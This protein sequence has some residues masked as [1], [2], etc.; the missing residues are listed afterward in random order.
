MLLKDK[1]METGSAPTTEEFVLLDYSNE[2]R[3]ER[4]MEMDEFPYDAVFGVQQIMPH[5]S[6][7]TFPCSFLKKIF[8][9]DSPGVVSHASRPFDFTTAAELMTQESD[10]I[11][12]FFNFEHSESLDVIDLYNGVHAAASSRNRHLLTILNRTDTADSIKDF[13]KTFATLMV[14]INR[15]PKVTQKKEKSVAP[16]I[17]TGWLF[18]HWPQYYEM[19][20][21]ERP[22]YLGDTDEFIQDGHK[23]VSHLH[24]APIYSVRAKL[25]DLK[26]YAGRLLWHLRAR[27]ELIRNHFWNAVRFYGLNALLVCVFG[28]VCWF[29][30][31]L[32]Y[33]LIALVV[34]LFAAI[35]IKT[36]VSIPDI[37]ASTKPS[38]WLPSSFE[39][40]IV[41][42]LSYD[43]DKRV[44]AAHEPALTQ[45][46]NEI[47]HTHH[48]ALEA[49]M[50][51]ISLVSKQMG[52]MELD[53]EVK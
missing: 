25:Y 20:K 51:E 34:C 21:R 9:V 41:S 45:R 42:A 31:D 2:K 40:E 33:I 28:S 49:R 38:P 47:L 27:K 1:V 15:R 10:L 37:V 36:S 50:S 16:E 17:A 4:N 29:S 8:L 35:F 19:E 3:I 22:R 12:F 53:F 7:R 11:F 39:E 46:C 18:P 52:F 23:V 32:Y 6:R 43:I 5:F 44:F 30:G 14:N 26:L 24:D 13:A 48:P